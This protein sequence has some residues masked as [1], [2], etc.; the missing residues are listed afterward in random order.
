MKISIIGCGYVGLV[1]GVCLANSKNKI[2]LHDQDTK[3]IQSIKSGKN[4]IYEKGLK[5][6]LN[7]AKKNKNIFFCDKLDDA[8]NKSDVAFVCVG[9]PFKN[10]DINLKYVNIVTKQIAK[11][12]KKKKFF[13]II[14]KSTIPPL[15]VEN[16]C[17]PIFEKILGKKAVES[18]N[19]V[20][21]PEFLREGNAIYD[22]EN[23]K[24]IVVGIKNNRSKTILNNVYN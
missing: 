5:K 2:F 9:T 11:A 16:N 17:I 22:F 8:I 3:R 24:R 15:T 12:L 19:F 7:F 4:L 21:N 18:L 13:T 10:K 6:K 20:F 14:Y 1:T 23:P